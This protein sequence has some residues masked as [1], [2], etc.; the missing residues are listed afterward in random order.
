MNWDQ[1]L[2]VLGVVGTI[3]SLVGLLIAAPG[4]KSKLVHV[5]YAMALTTVA[6][7]AVAAQQQ[8]AAMQKIERQAKQIIDSSDRTTDGS[9]KGFMLASLSFL[10]KN[11]NRFPD[12]YA[13]AVRVAE[14][15]GLYDADDHVSSMVPSFKLQDGSSAMYYLLQ[16]IASSDKG[17]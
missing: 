5:L 11:K 16:G 15:S 1:F 6:G 17:K 12:T 8:L 13:R 10:E 2:I 4:W 9:M 3:A 14:Q 7:Y